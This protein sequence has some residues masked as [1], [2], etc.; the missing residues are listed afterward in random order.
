MYFQGR[1]RQQACHAQDQGGI[2]RGEG[3]R[4]D[5]APPPGLDRLHPSAEL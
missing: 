1:T 2:L 5:G 3:P 4:V